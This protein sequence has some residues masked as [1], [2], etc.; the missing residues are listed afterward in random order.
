MEISASTSEYIAGLVQRARVAMDQIQD[1]TQGRR[2]SNFKG[3]RLAG[4]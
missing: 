3:N 2:S 1:L 4:C